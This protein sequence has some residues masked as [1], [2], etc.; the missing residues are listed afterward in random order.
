M[1]KLLGI[2][3]VVLALCAFSIPGANAAGPWCLDLSPSGYCDKI[4]VARD[5]SLNLYGHW[6]AYCDGSF[7]VLMQGSAISGV[8]NLVGYVEG[9]SVQFI[10]NVPG[11]LVDIWGYAGVG[12][13]VL[14]LPDLTWKIS[15]GQCPNSAPEADLPSL[16]DLMD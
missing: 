1:R 16:M 3:M 13:P 8:N 10:F 6:D 2:S 5:A 4:E 12:S 14:V 11:R 15:P 9:I 7:A